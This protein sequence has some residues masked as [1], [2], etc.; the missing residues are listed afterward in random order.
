MDKPPEQPKTRL[1][2]AWF[3]SGK[4]E[5]LNDPKVHNRFCPVTGKGSTLDLAVITPGL[6]SWVELFRVDKRRLWSV[7]GT[8]KTSGNI[9]VINYSA[10]VGWNRYIDIINKRALDVFNLI[11]AHQDIDLRQTA[12]SEISL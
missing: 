1:M 8:A 4:V 11:D 6:R 7:H 10:Q 9:Q 12:L 2:Q 3:D 5:L